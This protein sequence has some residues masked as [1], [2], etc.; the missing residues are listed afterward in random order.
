[1]EKKRQIQEEKWDWATGLPVAG[2]DVAIQLV[3]SQAQ[4]GKNCIIMPIREKI[5]ENIHLNTICNVFWR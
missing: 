5:H 3:L 1:M 2:I 4:R